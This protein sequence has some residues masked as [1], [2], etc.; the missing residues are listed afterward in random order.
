[1][2]EASDQVIFWAVVAARFFIPLAIPRY[3]LP[4]IITALILDG[5]DQTIFQL[6]TNLPLDNYQGYD[7]SLDIYYL[8]IAYISTIR[9]WQNAYAI[10]PTG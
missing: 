10:N 3:P 7:K 1:V 9:N 4:A 5:V 8:T 2:T 6:Y